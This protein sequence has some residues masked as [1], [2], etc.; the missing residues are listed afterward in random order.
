MQWCLPSSATAMLPSQ[1]CGYHHFEDGGWSRRWWVIS[2]RRIARA[3]ILQQVPRHWPL[4]WTS[5]S[6]LSVHHLSASREDCET[7]PASQCSCCQS[8]SSKP[9]LPWLILAATLV[10]DY[11]LLLCIVT[12]YDTTLCSA[13][14]QTRCLLPPG[15]SCL[16]CA[17]S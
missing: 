4:S 16:F 12:H 8:S 15:I 2:R 14:H 7:P 10:Y 3:Q 1:C 17:L 13:S 9:S 5:P 6:P 11:I